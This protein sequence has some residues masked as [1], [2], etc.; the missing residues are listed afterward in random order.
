MGAVASQIFLQCVHFGPFY[1]YSIVPHPTI[2]PIWQIF[3]VWLVNFE[4]SY[5]LYG[6]YLGVQT[7]VQFPFFDAVAAYF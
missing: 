3:Q 1:V 7:M 4:H 6:R 2:P 5:I